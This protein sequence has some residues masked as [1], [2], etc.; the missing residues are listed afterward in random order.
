MFLYEK[1]FKLR[2]SKTRNST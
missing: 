2:T 1:L